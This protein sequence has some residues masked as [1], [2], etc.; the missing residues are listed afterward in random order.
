MTIS[1]EQIEAAKKS[2]DDIDHT[3]SFIRNMMNEPDEIVALNIPSFKADMDAMIKDLRKN[4]TTIRTVLQSAL[5]ATDIDVATK[6]PDTAAL[7]ALGRLEEH[8]RYTGDDAQDWTAEG[9]AETIRATLHRNDVPQGFVLVPI[10]PTQ[11]VI[12]NI[13]SQYVGNLR[14]GSHAVMMAYCYARSVY[15]AMLSAAPNPTG[16]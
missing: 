14:D 4:G 11:E 5:S 2:I 12:E 13:V 1:K 10:E 9:D 8:A 15:S 6:T 16:E 7:D 3:L